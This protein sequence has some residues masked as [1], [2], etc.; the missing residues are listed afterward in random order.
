M[1]P[2]GGVHYILAH[3]ETQTEDPEFD[4]WCDRVIDAKK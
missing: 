1:F 2:Q 4:V 3:P